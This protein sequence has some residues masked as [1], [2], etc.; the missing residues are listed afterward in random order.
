MK[1]S[2]L[3]QELKDARRNAGLSQQ[4]VSDRTGVD[5]STVSKLESGQLPEIGFTKLERLFGLFA[6][7]LAPVPVK[8]R[9]PTLD[10]LSD[11]D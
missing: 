3:G 1:L 5:R 9:R 11:N 2:K 8:R 7:E 6:Q 4:E 10:E